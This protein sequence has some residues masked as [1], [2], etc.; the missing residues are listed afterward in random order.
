MSDIDQ[1]FQ[2]DG[3]RVPFQ[4]GQTI[5]QA[6]QAA[7]HFIPHLCAHPEFS[8]HGSCK[9]C[10]VR[11]N[12]RHGSACTT[13]AM[14]GQDVQSDTPALNTERRVLLQMLFVEGVHFCPGCEKSGN[15][16]LQALAYEMEML[17]P[18]FVQVH[19]DRPVD[20]SHPDVLLDLNR[21]ILCELCVRASR[22]V[23]GKH[24][25]SLAGRGM[26]A[27]I[28]VNSPTGK[29][30]DSSLALSDRAA[31]ICPVGAIL[32]KRVG[33][34]V[35]I[36]QRVYDRVSISGRAWAIPGEPVDPD[37]SLPQAGCP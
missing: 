1:S 19:P 2:L 36:G 6:A 29:L 28:V 10:T 11:V 9:L 15:C 8:P 22:D 30:G 14:P 20:G 13:A 21:C 5:L 26:A 24:V 3:Q 25:F 4:A 37:P 32:P 34:A 18:H 35:P 27:T 23:D 33:F 16:Q 12:G 17:S 31:H 7:G